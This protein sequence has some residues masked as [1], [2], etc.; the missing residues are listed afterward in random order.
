MD[1]NEAPM[2]HNNADRL[3]DDFAQITSM[4][5]LMRTTGN[6]EQ[7]ALLLRMGMLIRLRI[8]DIATHEAQVPQP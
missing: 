5:V 8:Q 2:Y 7:A 4:E 6:P 1:N 3:Q